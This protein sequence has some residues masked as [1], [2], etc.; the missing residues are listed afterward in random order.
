M[1]TN[2]NIPVHLD[3]ERPEQPSRGLAFATLLVFP[4]LILLIPHVIVMYFLSIVMIVVALYAQIVV[5][6]TGEYPS[7]IFR[8]TKGVLQWQVRLN[9]YVFGLTDI[10]PPFSLD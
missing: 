1:P 9:C 6:F 4:K 7:R 3:V 5:M 2:T 10:Y 8:I